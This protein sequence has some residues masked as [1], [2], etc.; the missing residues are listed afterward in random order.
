MVPYGST[1]LVPYAPTA[2]VP[3]GASPFG[4]GSAL[5][6]YASS[7]L[8]FP[9]LSTPLLTGPTSPLLL[10]GPPTPLM[11]TGPPSPLQLTGAVAVDPG[12][13]GVYWMSEIQVSKLPTADAARL[14]FL[15]TKMPASA[16]ELTELCALRT[17]A[18]G[19]AQAPIAG[20]PEHMLA[21]WKSYSGPPTNGAWSFQRWAAGHPSRMQNSVSGVEREEAYRLALAEGGVSSRSAVLQSPSGQ[22]RQ[23]DA[24]I[25]GGRGQGRN[26]I[27][28]KAG[29]ES[30]TTAPRV[31]GGAS[32]GATS[33]SNDAALNVDK[34]FVTLGD[35]VTWVFEEAPAGTLVKKA[36]DSGVSVIIRVDDAAGRERMI[37]LMR[38]KG[39]E[40][41]QA[42][43]DSVEI[44]I[45]TRD[46]LVALV[47]KR[48][49]AK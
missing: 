39:A 38:R 22:S 44:F 28:F 1:A 14:R 21:R 6:P 10:T 41:T 31:S 48:F 11:L 8:A 12:G 17:R 5:T 33:L 27:Q 4:A 20:T 45:G 26:L 30:L 42:E 16:D 29:Y 24:L 3:Y 25:E 9:T 18:A 19:G 34:E 7:G 23:I 2:I 49:G 32:R 43:I 47:A 35:R 37:G 46:Q 40:M 13:R 36:R 15:Q